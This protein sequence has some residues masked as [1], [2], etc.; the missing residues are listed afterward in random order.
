MPFS[1]GLD[2]PV[3]VSPAQ[4]VELLNQRSDVTVLDVRTPAEFESAH[5]PGSYNVPL[6]LLPEHTA[7]LSAAVGGPVVLVCRSGTRARQAEQALRAS[8]GDFPRLH[9]LEGGL[10]AWESAGY[11]VNRG[12]QRWSLERQVRGVAGALVLA[13]A[14]GSFVWQPL[15][16]VTAG[17]GGGL[18]FSAITDTCAM[19]RCL[20]KLPYNRTASCDIDRVLRDLARRNSASLN[21][22]AG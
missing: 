19:G 9:I 5:I 10:G 11:P 12:R 21:A 7:E 8:P 13:A 14:A 3:V 22:T 15:G 18:L 20:A 1:L 6:D 17:I 2:V 16:I 4:L